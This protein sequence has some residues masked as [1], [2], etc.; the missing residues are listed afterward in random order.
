MIAGIRDRFS[1][2]KA[3]R[4]LAAA[5]VFGAGMSVAP[6]PLLAAPAGSDGVIVNT[7]AREASL[8]SLWAKKLHL[9]LEGETLRE[10]AARILQETWIRITVERDLQDEPYTVA[11]S[12]GTFGDLRDAFADLC[13]FQIQ[14]A[15][16]FESLVFLL[17]EPP[18]VRDAAMAEDRPPVKHPSV[19]KAAVK[20]RKPKPVAVVRKDPE[21]LKPLVLEKDLAPI[22]K[23]DLFLPAIQ[24]RLARCAGIRILS[25]YADRTEVSLGKQ[26]AEAFFR[27]LNGMPLGQALDKV[28]TRFDYTWR[29]SHGWYLFRSKHWKSERQERQEQAAEEEEG[30]VS[31]APQRSR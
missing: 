3:A 7:A 11:C 13:G 1:G 15:P 21:L 19:P 18:A 9:K 25:D 2:K 22:E 14:P 6:R 4:L 30:Q 17:I 8:Q 20:G 16:R 26:S 31:A 10:L 5:A 28:A 27:S 29:K 12:N 24:V 23:E